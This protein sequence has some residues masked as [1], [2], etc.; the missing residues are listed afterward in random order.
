MLGNQVQTF[1][2]SAMLLRDHADHTAT[3]ALRSACDD[4][5]GV[6]CFDVEFCHLNK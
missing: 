4:H 6:S 3:L 1:N 2:D 5:D